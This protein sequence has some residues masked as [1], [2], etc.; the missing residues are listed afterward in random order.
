M[1]AGITNGT[2]Y[3][4]RYAGRFYPCYLRRRG[5]DQKIA[6]V[7]C[8]VVLLRHPLDHPISHINR[9]KSHVTFILLSSLALLFNRLRLLLIT[10]SRLDSDYCLKLNTSEKNYGLA[11][12]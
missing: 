3:R 10:I 7:V 12:R 11:H 4:A 8:A 9:K 2:A 6:F 5:F 1:A